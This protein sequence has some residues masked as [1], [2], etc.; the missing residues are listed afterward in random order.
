M[1]T[2]LGKQHSKER[3]SV[4][5]ETALTTVVFSMLLF[6]IFDFGRMYYF[7]SR[8]QHAVSQ[9]TR[10]A[11]TGN[12]MEDPNAPGQQMSRE[13][14]IMHMI[15]ALSGIEGF[16]PND[17]VIQ[18]MNAGGVIVAGAGGPG[19]VV[20]VRASWRVPILAPFLHA[21]FEGGE[22]EFS[23][24][25]SFRNEEFPTSALDLAPWYLPQSAVA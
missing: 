24:T 12:T 20:T 11:T 23:A 8:L 3:G 14:S 10:Y 21:M 4:L 6:A 13:D 2:K 5:I 16:G 25:T 1:K 19:S 22:Y 15:K 18:S 7:Q 17:I 9:S